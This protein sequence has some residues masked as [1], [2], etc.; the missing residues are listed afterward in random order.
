MY[1]TRAE[2]NHIF[3]SSI[4]EGQQSGR[5]TLKAL[6]EITSTPNNNMIVYPQKHVKRTSSLPQKTVLPE[7]Q[8][9]PHWLMKK[10]GNISKCRG[11]KEVLGEIILGQLELDFFPKVNHVKET[12]HW[13][14]SS[15]AAYYHLLINCLRKR[16]PGLSLS[17]RDVKVD[18]STK[19]D[20]ELESMLLS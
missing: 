5:L 14:L 15:D 4:S 10:L 6:L 16:Q 20:E 1:L 8:N 17:P 11:C 19:L 7:P 12:K 2:L 18:S 3:P 13:A 9:D